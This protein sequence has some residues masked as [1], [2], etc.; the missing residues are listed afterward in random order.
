MCVPAS[1]VT[2]TSRLQPDGTRVTRLRPHL[3]HI[4]AT[5]GARGHSRPALPALLHVCSSIAPSS[6]W[7]H[8][9]PYSPQARM[10]ARHV[11]RTV[12]GNQSGA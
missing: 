6:A 12:E 9:P 4:C 1:Q 11:A 3:C 7:V 10:T 2:R 5:P 8:R